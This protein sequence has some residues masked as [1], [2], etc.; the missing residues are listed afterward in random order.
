MCVPLYLGNR[1]CFFLLSPYLQEVGQRAYPA[2]WRPAPLP[3]LAPIVNRGLMMSRWCQ[4]LWCRF[5]GCHQSTDG[6]THCTADTPLHHQIT[7]KEKGKP[8]NGWG[9]LTARWG[10]EGDPMLGSN[11]GNGEKNRRA[12]TGKIP[13]GRNSHQ[14]VKI[15][16]CWPPINKNHNIYK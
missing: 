15:P 13:P 10:K 4:R 5:S 2:E 7:K 3:V 9:V 14:E 16:I 12:L 11:M 6:S 8:K 1:T